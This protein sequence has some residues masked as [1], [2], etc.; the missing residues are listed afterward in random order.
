[1]VL[2]DESAEQSFIF[3]PFPL[4][5]QITTI[6]FEI[7]TEWVLGICDDIIFGLH[8]RPVPDLQFDRLDAV[9]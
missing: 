7:L 2:N 1:M 9:G 3:S 5:L 4:L 8:K 6:P